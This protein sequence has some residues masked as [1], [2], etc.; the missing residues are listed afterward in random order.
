MTNMVSKAMGFCRI[1]MAYL[2]N[3]PKPVIT[4]STENKYGIVLSWESSTR[5]VELDVYPAGVMWMY[6][7][8]GLHISKTT[9]IHLLSDDFYDHLKLVIDSQNE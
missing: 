8:E 5:K 1:I 7:E 9:N 3:C 6:T 2:P 4:S